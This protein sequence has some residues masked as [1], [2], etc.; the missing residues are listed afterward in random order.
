MPPEQG[1]PGPGTAPE[2]LLTPALSRREREENSPH[3]AFFPASRKPC[4][5]SANR[6]SN[7]A[8]R[9]LSSPVAA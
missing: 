2:D 9:K 3:A 7:G 8:G 4:P 1:Y 5:A 6:A